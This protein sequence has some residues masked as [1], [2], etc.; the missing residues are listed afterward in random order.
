M[1]WEG[2]VILEKNN[3]K[4]T[5]RFAAL[6]FLCAAI[7][8][9]RRPLQESLTCEQYPEGS[10]GLVRIPSADAGEGWTHLDAASRS[11]RRWEPAA[12]LCVVLDL[13]EAAKR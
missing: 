9:R 13:T 2:V 5:F 8:K 12:D 7:L 6:T 10:R 1:G 11:G 4:P 3:F